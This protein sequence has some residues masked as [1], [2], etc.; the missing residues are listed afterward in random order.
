MKEY[1]L[2]NKEECNLPAT[3]GTW[4]KVKSFLFQEI[5]LNTPIILELTPAQDKVLKKVY[6][7][8]QEIKLPKLNDVF[9][10]EISWFGKNNK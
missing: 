6:N 8:F 10:N 5:D 2:T 9:N 1:F 3:I 4:G 7:F